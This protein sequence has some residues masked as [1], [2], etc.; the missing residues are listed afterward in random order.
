MYTIDDGLKLL[1]LQLDPEMP[2]LSSVDCT[3]SSP[4]CE[5]PLL[6]KK[7]NPPVFSEVG[8]EDIL[9]FEERA[10]RKQ[11]F[12][13]NHAIFHVKHYHWKHS[14][15]NKAFRHWAN[16]VGFSIKFDKPVLITGIWWSASIKTNIGYIVKI[17][18]VEFKMNGNIYKGKY[19]NDYVRTFDHGKDDI[20]QEIVRLIQPA[21]TDEISFTGLHY[22]NNQ[23]PIHYSNNDKI[24]F[25]FEVYGCDEFKMDAI[26]CPEGWYSSKG[27]CIKAIGKL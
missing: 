17:E 7:E 23:N 25:T 14:E 12:G 21:Y 15:G 1:N 20:G 13:Q 8:N 26:L 5:K 2:V 4:F 27:Y 6:T 11:Q 22:K 3:Y 18:N 19:L 24:A 10:G 16:D 9:Q